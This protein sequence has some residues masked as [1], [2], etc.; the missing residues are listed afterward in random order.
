MVVSRDWVEVSV[1]ECILGGL[2]MNVV[3]EGEPEKALPRISRSKIDAL[4][5]DCDLNGSFQLLRDLAEGQPGVPL[6]LM[7]GAR[8][9]NSQ[10]DSGAMFCFEKPISV[11][12]AVRTLSAAHTMIL[13]RHLR[14]QRAG[15][16]KLPVRLNCQGKKQQ[17]HLINLSQGGMQIHTRRS[18]EAEKGVQVSFALPGARS[19]M[20]AQAEVIW[21]DASGN[22]GVR[23][24]NVAPTHQKALQ[25]WLAQQFLAN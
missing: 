2:D 14:Y 8:S 4:V 13:D 17:A 25:R 16:D 3:V 19:E 18:I 1:L 11:E 23:F 5:V 15:L 12:H 7:G 6:V 20:T 10:R 24:V 22:L 21:Q 9:L